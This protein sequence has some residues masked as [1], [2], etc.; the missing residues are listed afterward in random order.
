[1]TMLIESGTGPPVPDG[2]SQDRGAQDGIAHV[3]QDRGPQ[4]NSQA[5]TSQDRLFEQAYTEL[6]H[7]AG[8]LMGRE[9]RVH[10]IQ[11][12]TLVHEAYLRLRQASRLDNA[13]I[14]EF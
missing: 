5:A 11:A 4:D 14:G 2:G 13:Q 7:I 3:S 1:M 8:R 6:R 10:T 12:T 9:F